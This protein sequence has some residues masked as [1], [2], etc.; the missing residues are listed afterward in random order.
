MKHLSILLA[1]AMLLGA[2]AVP[3]AY[4]DEELD[5]GDYYRKDAA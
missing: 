3:A 2:V 1:L 5:V 4:G